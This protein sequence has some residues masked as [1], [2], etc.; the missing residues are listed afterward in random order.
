MAVFR[1]IWRISRRSFYASSGGAALGVL[2]ALAAPA[3]LEAQSEAVVLAPPADAAAAR[4]DRSRDLAI[5]SPSFDDPDEM[6]LPDSLRRRAAPEPIR[7]SRNPVP[8]VEIARIRPP[9]SAST[10]D[11]SEL[12]TLELPPWDLLDGTPDFG[13]PPRFVRV[14]PP[15]P[16]FA[17]SEPYETSLARKVRT[18]ATRKFYQEVRRAVKRQWKDQFR[19]SNHLRYDL[20]EERMV[21]ISNIGRD[22]DDVDDLDY[23][24]TTDEVKEDLFHENY[25]GGEREIPLLTWGPLVVMDSGSVHFDLGAAAHER[26]VAGPEVGAKS[27]EER[28][29]FLATEDYR[30]DTSFKFDVDPSKPAQTG[31]ALSFIDTYGFAV[32][33]DIL[34]DVL[35]REMVSAEVEFEVND[36]REFAGFFNIVVKSRK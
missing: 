27:K 21:A 33:V 18:L 28:T 20:Y 16:L 15:S 35:G 3:A 11:V 24:Y 9:E 22:L 23:G 30:I 5:L 31:N 2:L 25:L 10:P 1:Q 29:P 13:A 12:E 17:L 34:T 32:E 14:P 19:E 8:S 4:A 7:F 6:E 36:H 26:D